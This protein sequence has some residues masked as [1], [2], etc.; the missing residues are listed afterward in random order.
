M[1]DTEYFF[2]KK[3]FCLNIFQLAL[4]PPLGHKEAIGTLGYPIASKLLGLGHLS[5]HKHT[6]TELNNI[7]V[8]SELLL[9]PSHFA[10]SKKHGQNMNLIFEICSLW[11]WFL[12]ISNWIFAGY[13][14]SHKTPLYGENIFKEALTVCDVTE[15]LVLAKT[16]QGFWNDVN[17]RLSSSE[18]LCNRYHLGNAFETM[19]LLYSIRP[20]SYIYQVL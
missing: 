7:D 3:I 17:F 11:T 10:D 15:N 12:S 9:F 19:H 4:L 2:E 16:C 1:N 6:N 13:T 20:Q 14:D 5:V 18:N 8:H